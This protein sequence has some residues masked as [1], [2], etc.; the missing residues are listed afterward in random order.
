MNQSPFTPGPTASATPAATQAIA[1]GT[2]AGALGTPQV[3]ISL[4]GTTPAVAFIKFGTSS[5][6]TATTSDFPILPNTTVCLTPPVGST[7]VAMVGTAGTF[8]ITVG[9]GVLG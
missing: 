5:A 7:H 6:V 3:V 4:G 2:G 1:L 8:W 9:H